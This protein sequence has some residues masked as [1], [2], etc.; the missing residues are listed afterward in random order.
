MDASTLMAEEF[1][2]IHRHAANAEHVLEL[3]WVSSMKAGVLRWQLRRIL[4][5]A[6]FVQTS[7]YSSPHIVIRQSMSGIWKKAFEKL[8]LDIDMHVGKGTKSHRQSGESV[9]DDEHASCSTLGLLVVLLAFTHGRREKAGRQACAKALEIFLAGTTHSCASKCE[10]VA[11]ERC[12]CDDGLDDDNMCVHL[13][14]FLRPPAAPT[15]ER[16]QAWLDLLSRGFVCQCQ[17]VLAMLSRTLK[18]LSDEIEESRHTWHAP[19]HLHLPDLV[20]PKGKKRT[21]DTNLKM[22]VAQ[23]S[24]ASGNPR[25]WMRKKLAAVL[26]MGAQAISGEQFVSIAFDGGRIRKPAVDVNLCIVYLHRRDATV[27]LPPMVPLT[28]S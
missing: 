20:G 23:G 10:S 15:Q 2:F 17:S 27:I 21:L 13:Q 9:D 8:H 16:A 22:A 25:Y 19:D 5:T 3:A 7:Q 24:T 18:E 4:P 28:E 11:D 26:K 1:R 6:G 14:Q 12:L